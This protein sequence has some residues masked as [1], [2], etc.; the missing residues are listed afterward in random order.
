[1][2]V[3]ITSNYAG[4]VLG[5][6]LVKASTGN[7]LVD[8]GHI[9]LEP[10][11]QDKFSIPRLRA[12]K[13]LQKRVEQP[14][15]E[16]SKGN[17]KIDEK[18]LKPQDFMAYTEFNPRSFERIWRKWQ[19]KG[20]LVFAQLPSEGQNALLEAL[21]GAVDFEL[22]YH[23]INGKY[24]TGEEDFFDGIL[25]KISA[26]DEV[27]RID[28]AVA[29]TESNIIAKLAEAR[30]KVPTT[31]RKQKH[32]KIFVSVEDADLYDDALTNKAYKGKDHT[33]KNPE[34]F[35]GIPIVALANWP[36]DVI[37]FA[38]A[39]SDYGT[40]FW[41]AVAFADD[42]EVILMDKVTNAGELYFFKMLMKADTNVAFGD[43]IVFYDGRTEEAPAGE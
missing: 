41:G 1:M 11:V 4:E 32:L 29:L 19:P 31:V 15:S 6:L 26:D 34:R 23:F 43:E 3:E 20:P 22:G 14:K 9:R 38:V 35:K 28:N 18:V 12:G 39:H 24:G 33:E 21:A 40:N 7:E 2:A 30:R 13:M 36:K 17:F 10:N 42:D 16:N 25:T 5:K 37:V 8:G 27:L